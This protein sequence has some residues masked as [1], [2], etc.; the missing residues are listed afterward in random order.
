[1]RLS[2]RGGGKERWVKYLYPNIYANI[3]PDILKMKLNAESI[4]N[5]FIGRFLIF[6]CQDSKPNPSFKGD[7][8]SYEAAAS[9]ALNI[10]EKKECSIDV[11]DDMEEFLQEVVYHHFPKYKSPFNRLAS[12]YYHRLSAMLSISENDNN[13]EIV[14]TDEALRKAE[15]LVYWFMVNHIS[16]F[17]NENYDLCPADRKRNKLKE[18]I[19]KHMKKNSRTPVRKIKTSF[20]QYGAKAIDEAILELVDIACISNDIGY[21]E[22][23]KDLP[24]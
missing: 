1:M 5:G 10:L 2:N 6:N 9:K 13:K 16:A 11:S 21:V 14:I 19:M 17:G 4:A 18:A 3:Q 22:Y 12:E 8:S 23:R 15:R 7:M 24:E 20:H